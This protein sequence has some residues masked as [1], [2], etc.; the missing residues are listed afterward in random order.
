[1]VGPA[2]WRLVTFHKS[3]P[4]EGL[5]GETLTIS[6]CTLQTLLPES[7]PDL[8]PGPGWSTPFSGTGAP[9]TSFLYMDI[10]VGLC[11]MFSQSQLLPIHKSEAAETN[12]TSDVRGAILEKVTDVGFDLNASLV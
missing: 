1:M 3:S 10:E 12:V 5:P 2:N 7:L 6:F 8:V 4:I 11:Y 9:A